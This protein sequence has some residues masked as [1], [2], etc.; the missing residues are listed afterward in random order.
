M[1]IEIDSQISRLTATRRGARVAGRL[2][3]KGK[4]VFAHPERSNCLRSKDAL[5]GPAAC[6]APAGSRSDKR[7]RRVRSIEN[8]VHQSV[9]WRRGRLW[10]LEAGWRGFLSLRDP[11]ALT[12]RSGH[13]IIYP[14]AHG[15][16]MHRVDAYA[17]AAGVR[18]YRETGQ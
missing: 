7:L 16:P 18:I 10:S 9:R 3:S 12:G 11:T 5:G 4:G 13:P 2:C 6:A 1:W 14:T 17:P 15:K 8:Q